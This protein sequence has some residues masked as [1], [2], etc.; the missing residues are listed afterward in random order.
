MR[1]AEMTAAE[2]R[3]LLPD[4]GEV[5]VVGLGNR[6]MTAD[7]LGS[8]TVERIFVTRHL[9]Q[10]GVRR[11]RSVSAMAPGVLGITGVETAEMVHGVVERT[12]PMAVIAVDALAA[13]DTDRICTTIQ[14]ANTGIQPGSGVGNH[15]AGLTLETLGIP[16]IAVG[17]P[18]VVHA[19]VIVRDALKQ[20]LRRDSEE[21]QAELMAEQLTRNLLGE[22]VVTPRNIDELVLHLADTLALAINAAL[23]SEFTLDEL[24]RRLH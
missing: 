20:I 18:M 24:S 23:Q 10:K 16:V 13:M 2:L 22:M 21:E 6:Y 15:R 11:L 7:A 14:V 8:R 3:R 9:E 12:K 5:L 1:L 4:E 19:S 17:I